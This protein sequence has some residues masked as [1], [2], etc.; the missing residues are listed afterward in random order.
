MKVIKFHAKTRKF[1][2]SCSDEIKSKCG[3]LLYDLQNGKTLGM[4]DSR[5][6]I[7]IAP[8]VSELRIKD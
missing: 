8:G 2:R 3:D 1:L 7:I 6:L 4:P 5:P